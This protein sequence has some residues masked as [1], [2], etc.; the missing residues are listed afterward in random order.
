[1]GYSADSIAAI[2]RKFLAISL[3]DW[4][5]EVVVDSLED[6]EACVVRA[7]ATYKQVTIYVNENIKLDDDHAMKC[8][9]HE[10]A[11]AI[12][13]IV[14][15][16][17]ADHAATLIAEIMV[18]LYDAGMA[19]AAL[20][21]PEVCKRCGDH[22]TVGYHADNYFDIASDYTVLCLDCFTKLAIKKGIEPKVKVL[23]IIFPHTA[24]EVKL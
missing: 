15:E 4:T 11:H 24:K 18:R 1:M 22:I 6:D 20:N 19:D 13:E 2:A 3:P 5:R 10:I 17:S 16:H 9:M 7:S 8:I 12:V 21:N 23:N 14:K